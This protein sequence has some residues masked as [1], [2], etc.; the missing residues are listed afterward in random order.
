[1]YHLIELA[2]ATAHPYQSMLHPKHHDLLRTL[3]GRSVWA[4]GAVCDSQPFGLVAGYCDPERQRGEIVSLVVADGYQKQGIGRALLRQAEEKIREQTGLYTDCFS[5]IKADDFD[6]LDR[7][8][9]EEQWEPLRTNIQLYTLGLREGELSELSWLE[10]LSL[11]AG[12]STFSW[13]ELTAQERQQV[14]QG[15]GR[16]YQPILS[17]FID[18]HKIDL[19]YSLGLRYEDQ[20]V[21]W[22]IVQQLASN[23]LLYKTLFVQKRFRQKARGIALLAEVIRRAHKTFPFGMCFV[24]QRN[25]S[26]L[27]FLNRR[28]VPQILYRK[29]S[30]STS[31]LLDR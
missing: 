8:F 14:E 9:R 1:M 19:H 15:S 29:L 25:E 13:G 6:W 18:E 27:R 24:E 12:F 22:M 2:S 3:N 17:P 21:G 20:V 23:M 30:V 11:P 28:L 5:I 4:F 10:K 16:R 26:M 31:K 7:F